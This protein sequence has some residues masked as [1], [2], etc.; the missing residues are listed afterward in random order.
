MDE[1]ISIIDEIKLLI[2]YAVSEEDKDKAHTLVDKYKNNRVALILLKEFY[3][4]LP[5]ARE[6]AVSRIVR[7]NMHQGVFLLGVS[8]GNHEYLFYANEEEAGSIG[9]YQEQGGDE[10]I[11][12]FFGYSGKRSFL[13]LHPS[14]A[15]FEDFEASLSINEAFCPV[16]ATAVGEF[17]HLGCPVEVCPW[18]LGQLS[19]CN[20]R[21]DQLDKVEMEGD[22]DLERFERIL[23]EKGRIRFEPGQGPSYPVAG[24]PGK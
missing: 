15:E 24:K 17:H 23:N 5:E 14:M 13:N 16:C 7:I 10:E 18:C 20:C 6:E 1:L 22:E 21:F 2:V 12:S 3:S 9:E 8:T 11:F 4:F 19:K